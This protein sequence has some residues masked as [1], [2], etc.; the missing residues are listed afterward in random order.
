MQVTS[1]GGLKGEVRA[2]RSPAFSSDIGTSLS[3]ARGPNGSKCLIIGNL[4]S[5]GDEV[6]NPDGCYVQTACCDRILYIDTEN[7][8]VTAEC[9]V[10]MDVLQQRLTRLGYMIPVTPGTAYLTLGGAIANDVHGKNHHSVGSFGCFV[11][12]FELV[13]T[14]GDVLLCSAHENPEYFAATIG[15]M[16]LTGAITWARICVRRISSPWLSVTS[17]RFENLAEFF[18]IDSKQRNEHEYTVAWIDCLARDQSLGRGIYS[19]A[20]HLQAPENTP[21]AAD[22]GRRLRASVPFLLPGSPVNRATVSLMNALFYW[23]HRAGTRR[24]RFTDW[25]YPLDAINHWNR[26]YGRRG[27]FQFQ[28]VVPPD[29]AQSAISELLHTIALRRQGSFLAVLK[30]FGAKASPG[31]MS[32]PMEGTTLALDFPNRGQSTREL[33][34]ELHGIA[35]QA[36]GRLYPAKDACSPANSIELGYPNLARFK[37]SIDPGLESMMARRLHLTAFA[38]AG[39]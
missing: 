35:A 17:Q 12:E 32:F 29:H 18:A 39:A 19:A 24:I 1:W 38:N 9:G 13:R 21:H 31:L 11:C 33:L 26:L 36:G 10:R 15:G 3:S 23:G 2:H 25:L 7:D 4:R 6:L 34:L 30:N 28:C 27:F 16:G 14:G 8:T 22:R 20:N 5:Y 37:R